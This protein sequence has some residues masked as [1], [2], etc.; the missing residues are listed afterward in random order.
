M[1][2]AKRVG[3]MWGLAVALGVGL[4]VVNTPAV[5]LA[6][7]GDSGKGSSSGESSHSSDTPSAKKGPSSATNDASRHRRRDATAAST[8]TGASTESQGTAT[9]TGKPG[10]DGRKRDGLLTSRPRANS[11]LARVNPKPVAIRES[12][13]NLSARTAAPS[14]NGAPAA[15]VPNPAAFALLAF[16]RREFEPSP[17]V[18]Q[19]AAT[20]S[21]SAVADPGFISS[22]HHIGKL[23][24]ISAADPDDDHYVAMVISTP[25][26]TNVLTSGT[27]PEDNLGFG[28]ASIGVAG[29]TVDTFTSKNLN[30]SFAIPVTDPLAPLFTLLVRLGF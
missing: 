30:F 10:N 26:F 12:R 11:V 5:A 24:L 14:A 17:T 23:T 4:A 16:A 20:V 25:R 21:T 9:A 6:A 29:H 28:V 27:D 19:P 22:T 18:S 15:P 8:S 2:N 1:E 13:L 7:P 3:C